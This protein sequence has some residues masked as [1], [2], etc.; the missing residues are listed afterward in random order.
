MFSSFPGLYPLDACISLLPTVETRKT[1]LETVKYS[2]EDEMQ[3]S[4]PLRAIELDQVSFLSPHSS[5]F[6]PHCN[7]YGTVLE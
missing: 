5:L 7:T 4:V 3:P 6:F 2:L 1:C